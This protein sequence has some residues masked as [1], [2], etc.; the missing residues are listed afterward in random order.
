MKRSLSEECARPDT[1][2]K[3]IAPWRCVWLA[4]PFESVRASASGWPA[5]LRS[6]C[7]CVEGLS[8]MPWEILGCT[9]PSVKVMPLT[10]LWRTSCGPETQDQHV[11]EGQGWQLKPVDGSDYSA[12]SEADFHRAL[13]GLGR[14]KSPLR[15]SLARSGQPAPLTGPTPERQS[16]GISRPHRARFR[17]PLPPRISPEVQ[18]ATRE[19]FADAGRRACELR[20][21]PVPRLGLAQGVKQQ[22][23]VLLATRLLHCGPPWGASRPGNVATR[24][25]CTWACVARQQLASVVRWRPRAGAP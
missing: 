17:P 24:L 5:G 21:V 16:P 22:P 11:W 13:Q 4:R 8:H 15:A 6:W 2:R 12:S 9:R 7:F 1:A 14:S 20:A 10:Q 23:L 18:S 25:V 3:Q 19:V